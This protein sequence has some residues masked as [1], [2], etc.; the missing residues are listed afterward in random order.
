MPSTPR[1]KTPARS[2]TSSPDAASSS[3]VDAVMMVS[4]MASANSMGDLRGKQQAEAVEDERV[5]GEHV[6]Q[7]DALEHL[8]EI[9]RNLQRDL[10]ALAADEGEREEQRRDQDAD[11]IQTTEKR[12]DDRREAVA[13][14]DVRL[15]VV[16]GRAHLDDA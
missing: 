5:A 15:E 16:H 12:H 11:R 13:G 6:E 1:F 4:R 14:R 7:Q 9:E 8:G 3:G 10:R 2:T